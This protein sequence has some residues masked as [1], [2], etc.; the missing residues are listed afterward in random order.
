MPV[1]RSDVE[2]CQWSITLSRLS[3]LD[4]SATKLIC[5]WYDESG[6]L[7]LCSSV[8]DT[9]YR[10]GN[11]RCSQV[12]VHWHRLYFDTATWTSEAPKFKF[13]APWLIANRCLYLIQQRPTRK[14]PSSS[15]STRALTSPTITCIWYSISLSRSSCRVSAVLSPSSSLRCLYLI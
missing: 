13:I 3:R 15:S 5:I 4:T 10:D 9:M 11:V 1:W 14:L 7:H 2:N 6:T 8:L 12:Q